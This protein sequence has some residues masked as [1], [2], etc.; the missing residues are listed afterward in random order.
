V[1]VVALVERADHVCCRYRV[2]AFRRHLEQAGHSLRLEP[3]PRRWWSRWL[4]FR[5]LRGATVL[6]QRRL[7]PFWELT[8]LRGSVRHLIF[9]LD[10]AV[11]LRD[12]YSPKGLYH[13]GRQR[14][15]TA[16]VRVC[17]AVVAGNS[18]LAEQARRVVGRATVVTIPTCVEPSSY[19]LAKQERREGTQLVWVGSSSTLQG[20]ERIRPLLEAIGTQVSGVALKIVCDKFPTFDRLPTLP[21]PWRGASEATEIAQADI[22]IS[23][24]PDDDWSR[25]KCGLKVLQYMAAG[26][27]V[28]TNPVGV[29]PEMVRHGENG[30]LATSETEWIAAIRTLANDPALRLRM[31]RAGRERLER[32]YSVQAGARAWLDLL[33]RFEEARRQVG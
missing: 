19:P 2:E 22:G 11:F 24:I 18:W 28:V 30:F 5:R 4:L 14:R 29:H 20:L 17:D 7:L 12:S 21:T 31:G 8:L 15:F 13:P 23:W 10:D 3:V 25:G 16:T 33:A 32:D 9:D 27:P 26:L 6:L 1:E